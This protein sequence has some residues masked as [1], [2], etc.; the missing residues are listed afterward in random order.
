MADGITVHIPPLLRELSGGA[1]SVAVEPP[2]GESFTIRQCLEAVDR[3]ARGMLEALLYADD[4]MPGYAIFI[5]SEQA[6]MGL[7]AKVSAG[8]EVHILPAIAGG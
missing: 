3:Q 4:L 5:D 2:P 6:L 8:A 7:K 1:E